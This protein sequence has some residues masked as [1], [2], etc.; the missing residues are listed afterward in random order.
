[1]TKLRE[2]AN[3]L[4][5]Q[6]RFRFETKTLGELLV[7]H[8]SIGV[9]SSIEKKKKNGELDTPT[10]L[11]IELI[12]LICQFDNKGGEYTEERIGNG[13]AIKLSEE[14]LNNFAKLFIEHNQDWMH[15][16]KSVNTKREV[17]DNG[18]VKISIEPKSSEYAQK[19]ENETDCEHLERL[20]N[21]E[22]QY[23]KLFYKKLFGFF[24]TKNLF[25]NR[26]IDLINEN[27]QI[28]SS[29]GNRLNRPFEFPD[30]PESPMIKT[31]QI[32]SSLAEEQQE[33]A[34]LIKNM[35]DLGVQLSLE[36]TE[37]TARTRFWNTIMFSLGLVTLIF[38]AVF[39]YCSFKSSEE[40]FSKLTEIL[41]TTNSNLEKQLSI[42]S[43][44]LNEQ[45]L[46][47]SRQSTVSNGDN[48]SSK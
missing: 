36:A 23:Q 22:L 34:R 27:R 26:A 16:R 48:L 32:L 39:S 9:L 30:L 28:S 17:N 43:E 14:E 37:N 20:I 24:P 7:H 46:R 13:E 47:N 33:M 35:N 45:K 44:I 12:S 40:S 8:F 42:E 2:I 1:M 4:A 29:L 6:N 15:I 10:K 11:V 41:G 38:T 5:S 19:Q 18:E 3:K 31:N 25:S 21:D